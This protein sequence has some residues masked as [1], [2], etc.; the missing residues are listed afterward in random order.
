MTTA[1]PPE[2]FSVHGLPVSVGPVPGC[3][4]DC[5]LWGEGLPQPFS[6]WQA[7]KAGRPLTEPQFRDLITA[8]KLGW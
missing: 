1:T 4:H 6:E 2:F 8:I 7:R 5:A 3:P